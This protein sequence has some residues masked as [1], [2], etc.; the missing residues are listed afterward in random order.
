MQPN[1]AQPTM[2]RTKYTKPHASRKLV[3]PYIQF[4]K[5]SKEVLPSFRSLWALKPETL[6]YCRTPKG[7]TP[8]P[9]YQQNYGHSYT[10]G[11]VKNPALPIPQVLRRL[12]RYVVETLGIPVNSVLLNFY[13]FKPDLSVNHYI[14]KHSDKL[15]D[16]VPDS[17][18]VSITV[19]ETRH[20]GKRFFEV[21]D[22]SGKLLTKYLLQHGSCLEMKPGCQE[23]FM[24]AVAKVKKNDKLEMWGRRINITLRLNK[25]GNESEC[26]CGPT[27]TCDACD[28]VRTQIESE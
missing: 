25:G 21:Y 4:H 16:L 11:G 26:E 28:G 6:D 5:I 19:C 2:T 10:Y 20:A 14:G 18:I 22:K 8:L 3:K 23:R 15:Q 24:H 27:E 9:R 7:L 17:S 13:D 12:V 1:A